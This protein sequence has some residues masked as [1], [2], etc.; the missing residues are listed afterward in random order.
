MRWF[1][2]HLL[3]ISSRMI[4]QDAFSPSFG[5]GKINT[6]WDARWLLTPW[7]AFLP[8]CCMHF[9]SAFTHSNQFPDFGDLNTHSQASSQYQEQPLSRQCNSFHALDDP[10]LPPIPTPNS[11]PILIDY[12]HLLHS[13]LTLTNLPTCMKSRTNTPFPRTCQIPN[14]LQS[15]YYVRNSR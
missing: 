14:L 2:L 6:P 7:I 4:Q 10:K 11:T 8:R 13:T 1:W 12:P 5:C 3:V 15:W 9:K